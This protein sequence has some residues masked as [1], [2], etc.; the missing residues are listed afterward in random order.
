VPQIEEKL[1]EL[2]WQGGQDTPEARRL[3]KEI[4]EMLAAEQR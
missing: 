2:A 1:R 4:E 3:T